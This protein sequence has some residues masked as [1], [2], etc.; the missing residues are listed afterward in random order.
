MTARFEFTSGPESGKSIPLKLDKPLIVGRDSTADVR[1]TGDGI[2]RRHFQLE[3]EDNSTILTD[4]GSTNG[5]FINGERV[6]RHKL[7]E[8]DSIRLGPHVFQFAPAAAAPPPRSDRATYALGPLSGLPGS[9]F[10][11]FT[12]GEPVAKGATGVIFRATSPDQKH[13]VA[14]KVLWPEFLTH[15]DDLKRLVRA[16][17]VM[18]PI[19]HPNLVA[20]YGAGKTQGF[21]WVAMELIEGRSVAKML[22]D[23]SIASQMDWKTA[24]NIA[25]QAARALEKLHEHQVVHRNFAPR[26]ILLSRDGVA[27][28]GDFALAKPL[29]GNLAI[30]VSKEGE[31][32]GET[33]Y[34]SPEQTRGPDAMDIRSDIYGLGA[35]L[36]AMLAGA[37]P[38]S[39]PNDL[40]MLK[41]IRSEMP[42][43]LA[44]IRFGLPEHLSD[45]VARMMAKDPANRFD[46]PAQL[47]LAMNRV[48]K[49]MGIVPAH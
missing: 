12:V 24:F 26:H 23:E 22:R 25:L 35:T 7:R 47:I 16:V 17:K 31:I 3:T 49:F 19:R 40:D 10:G 43:P 36:Y 13:V 2:S 39:A 11:D 45:L 15:D 46:D 14:L 44:K 37:P 20:V 33:A 30:A 48:G 41:L 29:A 8:G 42:K 4:L 34:M 28:V 9:R 1:I 21:G 6:E 38:F 32:I 27:K 18:M 5:T